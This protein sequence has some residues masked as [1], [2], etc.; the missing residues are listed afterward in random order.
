MNTGLHFGCG[1]SAA[2][3]LSDRGVSQSSRVRLWPGPCRF[4]P[5][6]HRRPSKR[7]R[8]GSGRSGIA[9]AKR[10][11]LR[12]ERVAVS[13]L[14]RYAPSSREH[15]RRDGL[16]LP[17]PAPQ[18]G[19]S[20]LPSRVDSLRLCARSLPTATVVWHLAVRPQP[21]YRQVAMHANSPL[22]GQRICAQGRGFSQVRRCHEP[23]RIPN[24]L[25]ALLTAPGGKRHS[26]RLVRGRSTKRTN[27]F[28]P[29]QDAATAESRIPRM[30]GAL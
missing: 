28:H 12:A 15:G 17:V 22:K 5:S 8:P 3:S 24:Q 29:G 2:A 13:E 4:L 1:I 26:T 20:R 18:G 16:G 14:L 25:L 9:V 6:E 19:R 11:D 30:R 23:Q 7:N 21:E 27:R 10:R